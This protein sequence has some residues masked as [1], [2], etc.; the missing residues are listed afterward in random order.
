MHLKNKSLAIQYNV[1]SLIIGIEYKINNVVIHLNY[2]DKENNDFINHAKKFNVI[3]KHHEK[4][5]IPISSVSNY[6]HG[7]NQTKRNLIK[8]SP[9]SP[10]SSVSNY[11]HGPNQTKRNLIKRSPPSKRQKLGIEILGGHGLHNN[12]SYGCSAGFWVF[13]E[14]SPEILLL[15]TVGHCAINGPFK[16][17]GSVDFYYLGL[18][19][20]KTNIFVETMETYD[21]EPIDRGYV[22]VD[23]KNTELA[24]FPSIINPDSRT[25]QELFVVGQKVLSEKD[26]GS[27]ICKS[28][29]RTHVTCGTLIGIHGTFTVDGKT[30]KSV[31]E[32]ELFSAEGDSGG[33]VFQYAID[34]DGVVRGNVN[35]LGLLLAG[36]STSNITV[37]HPVD[38]ILV[39]E[40]HEMELSLLTVSNVAI[41][42]LLILNSGI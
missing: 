2:N 10:I 14:E 37:F 18:N 39:D 28:G 3:I 31:L 1:N 35:I 6:Q 23:T 13:D 8:R 30:Y 34:D 16:P 5:N 41:L 19:S 12:E 22:A 40:D 20:L 4:E 25:Y 29:Y 21:F 15:A 7:P 33:P 9:P 24:I 17:D 36:N 42:S 27:T 38:K 32:A 11:Q 26:I